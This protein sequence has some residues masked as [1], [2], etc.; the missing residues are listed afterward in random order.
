MTMEYID[1]ESLQNRSDEIARDF[2]SK[3]P[4]HYTRFD[5]FFHNSKANEIYE[6]YPDIKD[7][8]WDGTTYVDQKNKF[9]K[10]KFES[11]SVFD[12]AFR[13]LNSEPFLRWLES[14][15][16]IKDILGDEE[17]FGGGLN[18]LPERSSTCT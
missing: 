5:G 12:K 8:K 13:E 14:V 3:K 6:N 2:L 9:Q 16:G 4:F 1:F 17:L 7:G 11:G 10:T 15:T 18:Q